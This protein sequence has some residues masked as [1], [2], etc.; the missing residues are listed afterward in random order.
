MGESHS[1]VIIKKRRHRLAPNRHWLIDSFKH[2][3]V[4]T[5]VSVFYYILLV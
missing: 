5:Y 2:L 4:V 3:I 1:A